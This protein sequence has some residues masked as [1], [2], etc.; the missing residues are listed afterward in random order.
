MRR[1]SE[2]NSVDG[3][4]YLLNEDVDFAASDNEVV[5]RVDAE[6][7]PTSYAVKLSGEVISG[8]I[9]QDTITIGDYQSFRKVR[10]EGN[11]VAEDFSGYGL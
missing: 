2:F 10:L 8:D 4:S 1:F 11:N 7:T 5:A 6:G 3:S 9:M